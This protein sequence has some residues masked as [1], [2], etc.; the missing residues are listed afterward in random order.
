MAG[1]PKVLASRSCSHPPSNATPDSPGRLLCGEEATSPGPCRCAWVARRRFPAEID[2]P[3]DAVAAQVAARGEMPAPFEVANLAARPAGGVGS[4]T[5]RNVGIGGAGG[6]RQG[7]A[8]ED[9]EHGLEIRRNLPR[10]LHRHLPGA[11][12]RF[13]GIDAGPS[14]VEV[15]AELGERRDGSPRADDPATRLE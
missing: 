12:V 11:S 14:Y 10:R 8:G 7:G 3:H 6:I 4:A 15:E 2:D 13:G 5:P 1:S 9:Q